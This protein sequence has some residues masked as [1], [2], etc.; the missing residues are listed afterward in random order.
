[1]KCPYLRGKY[2]Q[3]CE[4]AKEV[5]IPSQLEFKEYCTRDG[6]GLCPFYTK[7]AYDDNFVYDSDPSRVLFGIR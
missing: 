1:M 7:A 5:Y 4:A 3:S 6:H 2:L